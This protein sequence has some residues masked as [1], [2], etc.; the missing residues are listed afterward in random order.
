[1]SDIHVSKRIKL[2]EDRTVSVP[3]LEG[4]EDNAI[5]LLIH[6][7]WQPN[8]AQRI[9]IAEMLQD[10]HFILSLKYKKERTEIVEA[11]HA[12]MVGK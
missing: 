6:T 5:W 1:M 8:Q 9:A 3:D 4:W 2:D 10:Y 7:Y 11:V 12:R